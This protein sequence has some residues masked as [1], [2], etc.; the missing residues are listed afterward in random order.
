MNERIICDRFIGHTY[1]V[2]G[3]RIF[4]KTVGMTTKLTLSLDKQVIERAKDISR[5]KGTSLSKLIEDHL[6][7]LAEAE[8]DRTSYVKKLSGALKT[9]LA[10]DVN[11]KSAKGKYL[12]TKHGL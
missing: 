12:K 9:K 10:A 2:D 6:K 8:L 5:R 1:R 11:L 3:I 4:E 7:L